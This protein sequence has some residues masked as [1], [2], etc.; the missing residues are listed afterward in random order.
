ME[1]LN[2]ANPVCE[3]PLRLMPWSFHA[4]SVELDALKEIICGVAWGHSDDV[5]E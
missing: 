3:N 5:N 1:Y 2:S 4:G